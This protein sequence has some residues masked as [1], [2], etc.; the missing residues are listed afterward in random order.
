MK[1]IETN[2][3][4]KAMDKRASTNRIILHHA[5]CSICTVE[6]VHQWHLNNGW[7]GIGY[8]FFV[9]KNG[10]I[11]RGRPEDKIGAHAYGANYNSIGICAEGNY[12]FET[13]PQVQKNSL[14]ELVSYIKSKYG[15]SVVQRHSDVCSTACP[16]R[17]YPFNEIA[18]SNVT[19]SVTSNSNNMI[20]S[21]QHT[22]NTRYG[23]NLD[24]DGI[25]GP[26]T[27]KAMVKGLQNE[28]K[29]QFG[30]QLEI[31]GIFGPITK[32]NCPIVEQGDSGN[33]TWLIQAR[34]YTEG[35][36]IDID[37]MYGPDTANKVRTF[38]FRSGI[39]ADAL[40]GPNTFE[41]LFN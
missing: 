35:Y 8:H 10:S 9:R 28:F 20:K 15:I 39:T 31:D 36:T 22:L 5:A 40:C 14:K 38:Q 27:K 25:F 33:I 1:I 2:L 6:D 11:Y 26:L 34:L 23:F 3:N 12:E 21:I 41:K 16:G 30:A 18:N 4:F 7:E 13:M 32:R 29:I 17:N 24:E 19:V 37:G